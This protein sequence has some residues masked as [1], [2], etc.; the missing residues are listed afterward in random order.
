MFEN[1]RRGRQA[2]NFTTNVPKILDLKSSSEQIFSENR[3]WVPLMITQK[4]NAVQREIDRTDN[5]LDTL[6]K[7]YEIMIM[8]V[9]KLKKLLESSLR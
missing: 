2:R 5:P 4:T 9:I 7:I 8:T 1:H 3:R 6:Y